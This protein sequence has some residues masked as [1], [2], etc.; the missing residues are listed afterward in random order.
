VLLQKNFGGDTAFRLKQLSIGDDL[1][2]VKP[3]GKPKTVGLE[4][5][6]SPITLRNDAIDMFTD[7]LPRL[8]TQ[9]Q[10]D[11]RLPTMIKVT[12]RQYDK[13]KKMS[14]R[15]TKQGRLLTSL[16]VISEE[17]VRLVDGAREKIMKDVINM[18]D[19]IVG[20]K[21]PFYINLV[22]L[23]FGKF[24][25]QKEGSASIKTFL[26]SHHRHQDGKASDQK[27]EIA[28]RS[29]IVCDEDKI[30]L[31]PP[32]KRIR[33]ES[34]KKEVDMIGENQKRETTQ[35]KAQ[36]N[37]PNID[38]SVWNALPED[39]QRELVRSW[40]VPQSNIIAPTP[41]PNSNINQTRCKNSFFSKQK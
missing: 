14:F 38:P 27:L 21:K 5:S 23:C 22:G 4:D 36:S 18:F 40:A 3:S 7:L 12:V 25:E 33:I 30:D 1:S 13:D 39:L 19:H 32:A 2:M 9:I 37:S 31:E 24:Q 8:V 26:T 11:G 29:A 41:T 17:K 6:C 10:D 28:A 35:H 16:F 15:E 34:P 20:I